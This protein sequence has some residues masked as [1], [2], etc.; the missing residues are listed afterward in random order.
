[1]GV[2]GSEGTNMNVI[3][4]PGKTADKVPR[5]QFFERLNAIVDGGH[6]K[7]LGHLEAL[8]L[9]AYMRYSDNATGEAWPSVETIAANI[10]RPDQASRVRKAIRSLEAKSFLRTVRRGGGRKKSTVRAVCM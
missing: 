3:D 6:L 4:T 10:G 9:M 1:M 7:S 5:G 2:T 8:V